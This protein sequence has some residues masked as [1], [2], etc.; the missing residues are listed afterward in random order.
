M[1]RFIG[2]GRELR[3]L[4]HALDEV[5]EAGADAAQPGQC[6]LMRG[7]RR[8][9][10]S[11]LVEEFLRRAEVPQLFFTAGGGSA[12]DE[13]VELLDAVATSTLPGKA[14]F[15]EEAPTQWN[16]AFRLL[17]E[18]LPD[19]SPSVVVIDEV[20][21][22]MER[23]DAFE[24]MLQRA[25]D[26]L[27]SRK[28][29]LLLL[30]GS[31]LSMMEALNSYD[32]PFHQRGREM[33]VGPLNPADLSEML[34][35]EPATAFDAALITGGLPL[36]CREWPVGASMWEFL[37]AALE[38]PISALLV[39]AE[40]SL[41]AEFPPQAMGREVLR[42]IGTGERTFTNIARAAGGIAHSTLT[43]AA[44]LLID[45]RVVA[46]ELPIALHPSKERRYRVADPYLRFWLAFLDPHMAEIERMR[47]DL[48]LARVR[49]QWP[50]WRG[51]AVEPLIRESL[52]RILPDSDLPA[53]PAVGG[54]WTRSND[55]EIDLVGADRQPVAKQ[56]LFLGSIKWLETSPFDAHD[57]A[58]LHKHRAALTDDPIP[59]VAV[60]RSGVS[61]AGLQATYGPDELLGAWRAR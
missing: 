2:R 51:R 14:L 18:I 38:N 9:G 43:R 50:S 11:T 61:C 6:L 54:Y 20:P 16:A 34:E 23:I 32:R 39:S 21:Y 41:A 25:W 60:S 58:A 13:L 52:V 12:E 45:K 3:I 31:D 59:L 40:R 24:G 4:D 49:E 1:H 15:A 26:R 33:V 8:V 42:A 17:A 5:R 48:T 30:V 53:A 22:L 44:D 56:L 10:K 7:R 47:G 27:L 29:V 19:D 46:A 55:V 28:P 36:I 37:G 57:L 35:L